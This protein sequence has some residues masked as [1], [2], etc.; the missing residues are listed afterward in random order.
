MT[1]TIVHPVTG[2]WAEADDLAAAVRAAQ[3]LRADALDAG[4]CTS[5]RVECLVIAGSVGVEPSRR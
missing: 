2:D 1:F 3:V 4:T 5:P